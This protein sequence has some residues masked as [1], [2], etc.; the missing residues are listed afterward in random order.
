VRLISIIEAGDDV[1]RDLLY[2]RYVLTR[3]DELPGG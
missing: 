2:H 3:A 1:L